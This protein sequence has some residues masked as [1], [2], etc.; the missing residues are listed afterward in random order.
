MRDTYALR[1]VH[2]HVPWVL[3]VD[4]KDLRC[5][6]VLFWVSCLFVCFGLLLLDFFEIGFLY[7]ALAVLELNL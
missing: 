2:H 5:Q 3:D 7:V 1:S 4:L 6:L